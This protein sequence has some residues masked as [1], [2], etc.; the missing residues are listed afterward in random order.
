MRPGETVCILEVEPLGHHLHYVRHLV[1]AAGGRPVV[2]LTTREVLESD[3]YARLRDDTVLIAEELAPGSSPVAAALD[4][5]TALG[6]SELLI[7]D[8]DF[9]LVP[10]LKL[11]RRLRGGGPVVRV[12]V[13]RTVTVGGPE[14]L[15]FATLAKQAIV[16]VLRRL[17]GIEVL[18]L[19]DAFG[20]VRRRRGFPGVPPVQDPVLVTHAAVGPRPDWFPRT[21]PLV[22]VFGVITARKNVPVVVAAAGRTPDAVVV[23]GGRIDPEVRAYL[24]TDPTARSLQAAGRLVA[25]DRMLTDA[26]FAAC[27][28]HVDVLVALYDNDAPSGIL[29]EA[30]LKETPVL[31]PRGGWLAAVVEDTGTGVAVAVEPGDVARG[32]TEL[33]GNADRFVKASRAQAHRVGTTDFTGRLLGT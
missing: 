14:P 18:F 21:G 16:Q 31:V 17:P 2:L 8:G 19:T 7:P 9:H 3:E 12:L 26:E 1:H 32:I 15:R 20:V 6:A 23:L 27:L 11:A 22:G 13:M 25:T 33:S 5:A 30:C 10:L 29:A 24:D 28:A 4:R